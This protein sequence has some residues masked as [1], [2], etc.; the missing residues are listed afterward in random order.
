[1]NIQKLVKIAQ[2]LDQQKKYKLVDKITTAMM[3][4]ES[5]IFLLKAIEDANKFNSLVNAINDFYNKRDFDY[6]INKN[7]LKTQNPQSLTPYQTSEDLWKNALEDLENLNNP[8][9]PLNETVT[10]NGESLN[11]Y[12]IKEK[13]FALC[14]EIEKFYSQIFD[15]RKEMQKP[16][17]DMESLLKEN[18]NPRHERI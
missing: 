1:M 3:K 8:I 7:S 4:K 17:N 12:E 14:E 6:I 5:M 13:L 9:K 10:V 16:L 18:N 11:F 2:K 15:A